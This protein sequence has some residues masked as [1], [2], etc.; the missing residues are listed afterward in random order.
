MTIARAQLIQLALT[1]YY[2]CISR[3]VR[4]AFL[5]GYD[6]ATQTSFDHRKL[7]LV[8]R[9]HLLS[10]VF[11]IDVAAYAIMSNHY[12]LVLNVNQT[13]A[14]KLTDHEVAE[15]WLM[16]FKG[17]KLVDRYL[18]GDESVAETAQVTL[19]KWRARLFDISWFMRSLNEY[20]AKKANEE[21]DCT[22]RFWEGRFKSQPLLDEKALL[23]AMTYVDLNPIRAKLCKSIPDSEFTS[24]YERLHGKPCRESNA[25]TLKPLMS[26]IGDS[27]DQDRDALPFTRRQ[28]FQLLDWSSRQSARGKTGVVDDY[29][30]PLLDQLSFNA[31]DWCLLCYSLE[32]LGLS[33]MGSLDR[34]EQFYKARGIKRRPQNSDLAKLFA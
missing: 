26:F 27:D 5:C 9:I 13:A 3:C 14:K 8:E 11:T 25:H 23:A 1:Q 28:Y 32:K 33:A 30:P 29:Q 24:A 2:H 20:I 18:A 17:N 4:R 22:G 19:A 6:H 16:L 31:S 7:W 34:I 12:H 10:S 21:D 15:R